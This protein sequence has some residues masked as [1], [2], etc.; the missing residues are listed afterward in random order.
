[1]KRHTVRLAQPEDAPKYAQWLKADAK[2][3]FVDPATVGYRSSFTAVVE[4]ENEPV[5]M[6]S[7]HP[8]LMLE[9]VAPNPDN[10]PRQNA[11]AINEM[12]EA[13]KRVAQSYGITEIYFAS[14]H[15]PL[16]RMVEK[17]GC[18]RVNLPVFRFKL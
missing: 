12:F 10:S 1:L 13:M 3:N 18:T 8:V 5:L 2:I 9:A 4:E 15:E 6:Q 7:A 14:A 16:Q 17:R 11:R